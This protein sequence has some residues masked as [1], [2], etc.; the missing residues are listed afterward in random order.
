M[1]YFI[2]S[3]NFTWKQPLPYIMMAWWALKL[4]Y[5]DIGIVVKKKEYGDIHS[6]KGPTKAW[7]TVSMKLA[8]I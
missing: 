2:S 7:V 3:P 5:K 1:N 6:E 4:Y 8:Q